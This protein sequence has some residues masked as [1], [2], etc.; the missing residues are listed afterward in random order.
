MGV[1]AT[2]GDKYRSYLSGEGEE[3]TEWIYGAPPNYDVVNKLFEEGR[4]KIWSPGSLEE[5]VQNMVKT[6]EME[7]FHKANMD[8]YKSVD[9]NK[10]T[11]SLNGDGKKIFTLSLLSFFFFCCCL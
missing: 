4:T 7:M 1:S 8:D 3:N 2:Q 11:F 6:W 5:Q 9:P 10:Y